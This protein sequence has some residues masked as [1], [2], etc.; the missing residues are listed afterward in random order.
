MRTC[1]CSSVFQWKIPPLNSLSSY[2]YLRV[3]RV[4]VQ[5]FFLHMSS[6]HRI[7]LF[8]FFLCRNEINKEEE[9]ERERHLK[10]VKKEAK[11]KHFSAQQDS[12]SVIHLHWIMQAVVR[13][14]AGKS[15]DAFFLS[16]HC[17]EIMHCVWSCVCVI[18]PGKSALSFKYNFCECL[19][20]KRN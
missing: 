3:Y 16:P 19:I 1:V 5:N 9:T 7:F 6:F 8:G 11:L 14:F 15:R 2:K 10:H 13:T 12:L 20:H 17:A 4:L 18:L